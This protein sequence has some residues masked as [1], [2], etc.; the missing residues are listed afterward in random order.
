MPDTIYFYPGPTNILNVVRVSYDPLSLTVTPFNTST[1]SAGA[2]K[3]ILL[4][5]FPLWGGFYAAPDGNFY[6]VTGRYELKRRRLAQRRG[7]P[8]VR[9]VVE[10]Q[11][12]RVPK[13]WCQSGHQGGLQ[14]VRAGSCA[15]WLTGT[16]LVVHMARLMY[17]IDGVHHQGNM[18]FEVNTSNMAVTPFQ[19]GYGSYSYSSHS[20]NQLVS[21]TDTDLVVADHGDAYP[22]AI[23]VGVASGYPAGTGYFRSYDVFELLGG[24]GANYTGTTLTGLQVGSGRALVDRQFRAA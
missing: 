5:D 23:Q 20:F 12:N 24:I 1:R 6:V 19:D 17:A 7:R 22:R 16:K 11:R 2:A 9:L 21:G 8:Q 18:T 15:M 14:S 13:G 4:P 10:S 3:T